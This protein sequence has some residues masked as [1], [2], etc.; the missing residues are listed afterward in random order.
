M[1]TGKEIKKAIEMKFNK[2]LNNQD[3]MLRIID[4]IIRI[5]R[6]ERKWLEQRLLVIDEKKLV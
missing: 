2:I 5:K 6:R 1:R 4:N 3:K